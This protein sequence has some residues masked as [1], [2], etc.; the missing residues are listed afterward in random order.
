MPSLE[1]C[2]SFFDSTLYLHLVP[3]LLRHSRA[4]S[5][6]EIP[7]DP[8]GRG[9]LN[10]VAKTSEKTRRSRLKKIEQALKVAVPQLEQLKDVKDEAGIPHLEAIYKHWRLQGAK[11]REDQFSDGTLRLI[12]LFWSLLEGDSML[13]LEEPELSLNT[14]IVSRLPAIIHKLQRNKKRQVVITT[15]SAE[16]LSDPSIG[17]EA[18]LLLKPS[19]EGT[20]GVLASS[21]D[22]IR[23]LLESGM[24]AGDAILPHTT[25]K[26]VEQ[27]VLFE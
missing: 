18:V 25:P 4:F 12:G 11:Q 10:K 17:G 23:L 14:A 3:Q 5:G 6:P 2:R 9:F 13:L 1:M 19:A 7:G 22:D 27:L 20:K 16:L 15:H 26:E 8:F 21:V 24:N